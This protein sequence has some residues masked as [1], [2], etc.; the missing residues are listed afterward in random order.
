LFCFL[1]TMRQLE[2]P[3]YT[4]KIFI[5]TKRRGAKRD[6][7]IVEINE[8]EFA[9][10]AYNHPNI[11][12]C[13]TVNWGK[14]KSN[15]G[16]ETNYIALQKN[17][18]IVAASMFLKKKVPII[19]KHIFYAGRGF[20]MDYNDH[21]TLKIFTREMKNY[22]KRQKGI[23]VKLDPYIIHMEH[24]GNYEIVENGVNNYKIIRTLKK[25][26]YVHH[27]YTKGLTG[28][29][30]AKPRWEYRINLKEK[31]MEEIYQRFNK[32]T[33]RLLKKDSN[34]YVSV[35]ELQQKELGVFCKIE[36][37]T[38]NTKHF[39][40]RGDSFFKNMYDELYKDSM[41]KVMVA[42]LDLDQYIHT[43]ETEATNDKKQ[44]DTANLLTELKEER[45]KS[46]SK[47]VLASSLFIT[48]GN[49][50][51]Y[52]AGGSNRKYMKYKAQFLIQWEM[53]QFAKKE[54]YDYYNFGGISGDNSEK[55]PHYGLWR[56]KNNFGGEVTEFIG[57]FDLVI[58]KTFYFL[59][60][61]AYSLYSKWQTR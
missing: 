59:Y 14:F 25:F 50:I 44:Y 27:G 37:N 55:N 49:E 35:R 40:Y 5:I 36:E 23:F 12:F 58:N 60:N 28:A 30:A 54:N 18:K 26:G 11:H 1:H 10:F 17:N 31:S 19:N 57:E 21:V 46:G 32:T 2:M 24:S 7:A 45:D 43:L 41:I 16:W 34:K 29:G 48:V 39:P 56:F 8:R 53:I 6:M 33:K 22:L 38:C 13:Q 3:A 61:A 9:A 15:Y 51:V 47:V 52:F 4:H 42:E 20:L